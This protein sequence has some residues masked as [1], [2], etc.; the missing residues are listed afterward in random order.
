ML[1]FSV[2]RGLAVLLTALAGANARAQV[3]TFDV[4]TTPA[5]ASLT[6]TGVLPAYSS[7]YPD[8]S[9]SGN[10]ITYYAGGECHFLC[11]PNYQRTVELPLWGLQPGTYQL[12]FHWRFDHGIA[13]APDAT[14]TF[15]V[16]AADAIPTAALMAQPLEG[17][18]STQ[19][20]RVTGFPDWSTLPG[21]TLTASGN[22]ITA[23]L[24]SDC[25]ESCGTLPEQFLTVNFPALLAGT[26]QLVVRKQ[27]YNTGLEARGYVQVL[28]VVDQSRSLSVNPEAIAAF[29]PATLSLTAQFTTLQDLNPAIVVN[30]SVLEVYLN[31]S[32]DFMCAP[33]GNWTHQVSVPALAPGEYEV[34]VHR[35]SPTGQPQ[36]SDPPYVGKLSVAAGNNYQGLW[37]ASPA[38]VESGWGLQVAHQ[39]NTMFATWYT[40]DHD[41][42]P[43]WFVMPDVRYV[44]DRL[45]S[46]ALYRTRSSP[47]SS[48]FNLKASTEN[49]YEGV[50]F[51]EFSDADNGVFWYEVNGRN[52]AKHITRQIF[53]ERRTSCSF[54]ASLPS[55]SNYQDLWW[56]A[57]SGSESGWGVQVAHQ[58]DILFATFF[59]YDAQ[60][61]G[62]W[63]VMPE[64]R[65]TAPG[66][67]AGNVY[68]TRGPAYDAASWNPAN[69]S[70]RSE[71]RAEFA[72]SGNFT[73]SFSIRPAEGGTV[74]A[75]K[76]I[77][78]QEFSAFKTVCN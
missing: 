43:T 76:S 6:L 58:G 38:G 41:G 37:W 18:T 5:A 22:T 25:S 47:S 10:R 36:Q 61:K 24:P 55:T 8:F 51:F 30:G 40:Y 60:G 46:G 17:R 23:M 67:Y 75:Q 44:S 28:T 62:R 49:L 19:T 14:K 2:I 78:R 31:A 72:F 29:Q 57:P 54:S 1:R 39:G 52:Y 74:S 50:V 66:M 13:S 7:F 9:V 65:I 56:N 15:T 77:T 42:S 71:G 16:T 11:P 34:R 4:D 12:D 3:A 64:G 45:Y 26:Y 48:A 73:G 53:S 32:C 63:L 70:V 27:S 21:L 33:G 59:G 69:V 68:S 20:L 35:F